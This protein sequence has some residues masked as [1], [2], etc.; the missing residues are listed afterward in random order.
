M[1]FDI[2]CDCEHQDTQKEIKKAT[3]N[4]YEML[5]LIKKDLFRK[6]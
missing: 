4:D 6:T 5:T 3:R 1:D 2:D